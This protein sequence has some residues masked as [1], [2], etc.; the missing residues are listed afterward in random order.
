MSTP[1]AA[2]AESLPP[3][4]AWPDLA[5]RRAPGLAHGHVR[6]QAWLHNP[7]GYNAL[8]LLSPLA[9][10]IWSAADGRS[11]ADV[12]ADLPEMP[13][14][15]A[16]NELPLLWRNGFLLSPGI[17]L[18]RPPPKTERV[19]NAWLHLTNACNLACPYCYIHK[20][21]DHMEGHVSQKTLDAIEATAKSGDVERIHVRFAGGEPMLQFPQM[22]QFFADAT[23]RCHAHGVKFSAAVLTNGVLV[24]DGAI[25]WLQ[26]NNV[27]VSVSI[28]G[29][30]AVQD[31]MRP[32]KGG[33]PSFARLEAGLDAY[34][35]AGIRPYMLIT[36]GESNIDGLAELTDWL[37]ARDLS[38][39]YS[40]VRDL[41]WGAGELDDR[42]G[43]AEAQAHQDVP[44]TML[45][46]EALERVQRALSQA[47]DRIERHL[48]AE[49]AAG[50]RPKASFR[51]SHKFCDLELWRPIEQAC[52]A[53][54]SYVA[55]AETGAV[56][57]CQAA[58]HHAGT[59]PIR[60]ESLLTQARAQTQ[61][62]PFQRHALNA[63]CARC[64]FKASCAGGCPLLLYRREGHVDGRSPYCE[65]FRAVI[66]RILA[67]SALEML[68]QR[69][70]ATAPDS[71]RTDA[72]LA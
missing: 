49:H 13:L 64:P 7:H 10:Q 22:Q 39:R 18:Q 25:A 63:E 38:F 35:A 43:A 67:I 69:Q 2:T 9:W 56:S 34:L 47:Y 14:E 37:L 12:L 1:T 5:I 68:L 44:Q 53:G 6:G 32:V 8:A 29:V 11:V 45:A 51:Q 21:T 42:R 30:G 50:R 71:G 54:R 41:E 70:A 33:G 40:L 26:A 57:P 48:I 55:I 3:R 72:Q 59:Q 46:G 19:F 31:A 27:S 28:D 20:S 65:V 52:G 36:V 4:S 16:L 60:A 17:A 23:A 58:L 62:Q 15:R 61:F 66:P 24:P